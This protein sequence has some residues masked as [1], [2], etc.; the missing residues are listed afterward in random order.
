MRSEFERDVVRARE[1]DLLLAREQNHLP[2][3]DAAGDALPHRDPLRGELV[4]RWDAGGMRRRAAGIHQD[5]NP[6]PAIACRDERVRVTRVTHHPEPHVD[7]LGFL[8]DVGQDVGPAILTGG[9]AE[10]FLRRERLR[11]SCRRQSEH[12]DE[13][14]HRRCEGCD[15]HS[16][17]ALATGMPGTGGLFH[18]IEWLST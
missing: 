17:Y 16:A 11:I 14:G 10:P 1:L 2:V 18:R 6:H 9:I 7:L 15:A 13:G 4:H 3:Q 12:Q 5:T 8:L